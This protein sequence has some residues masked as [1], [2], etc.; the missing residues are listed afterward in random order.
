MPS[1]F[2]TFHLFSFPICPSWC[3]LS[4]HLCTICHIDRSPPLSHLYPLI[5]SHFNVCLLTRSFCLPPGLRAPC[6]WIQVL[7][8]ELGICRAP[9]LQDPG[10]VPRQEGRG[11]QTQPGSVSQ[12]QRGPENQIPIFQPTMLKSVSREIYLLLKWWTYIF[13]IWTRFC[14]RCS[15][16]PSFSVISCYDLTVGV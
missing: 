14:S 3:H 5:T 2:N 6:G 15:K 4:P 12:L 9:G 1:F 16:C 13:L 8:A 10:R 11:E 7:S